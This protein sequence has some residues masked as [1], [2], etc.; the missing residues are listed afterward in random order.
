MNLP[1]KPL[2]WYLVDMSTPTN[3]IV[4]R[5]SHRLHFTI[6]HL[7]EHYLGSDQRVW[8]MQ[9]KDL[10]PY[11]FTVTPHFCRLGI[12]MHSRRDLNPAQKKEFK[13]RNMW[14]WPDYPKENWFKKLR[15]AFPNEKGVWY[16]NP[17]YPKGA[18][19]VAAQHEFY[20]NL[21][22]RYSKRVLL[23]INLFTYLLTLNH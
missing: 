5:H 22:Y 14:P 6:T 8:I 20:K 1:I 18:Y 16:N 2:S 23:I 21:Y 19:R 3:P 17:A 4:D 11:G 13:K 15:E 10:I 9:G 7:W 12:R